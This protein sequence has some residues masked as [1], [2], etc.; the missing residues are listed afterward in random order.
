MVVGHEQGSQKGKGERDHATTPHFTFLSMTH[1][2]ARN[3]CDATT[4]KPKG[5]QV[6]PLM[7][8]PPSQ[9]SRLQAITS[10]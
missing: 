7:P 3:L 5:S 6:L 4:L 8:A 1:N 9:A 10:S 2:V